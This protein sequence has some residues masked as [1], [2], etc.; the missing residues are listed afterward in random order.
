MVCRGAGR[1][2]PDDGE[3]EWVD[4]GIELTEF[5]HA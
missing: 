2:D 3:D 4:A 1:L 5:V